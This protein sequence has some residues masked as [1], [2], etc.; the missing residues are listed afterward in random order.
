MTN[1][2]I[3]TAIFIIFVIVM[4]TLCEQV[5]HLHSLSLSLTR[6]LSLCLSLSSTIYMYIIF[7]LYVYNKVYV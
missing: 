7:I 6:S 1:R 5:C 2:T 3:V 4:S